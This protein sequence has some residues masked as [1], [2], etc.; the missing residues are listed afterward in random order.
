MTRKKVKL[1]FIVNDSARKTTYKKR[2]KGILKKIEELSILCGIEACAIVYSPFEREPEVWPSDQGVQN[3][4]GKFRSMPEIEQSKKMVNQEGFIGQRILKCNE[5]LMKL[6]KDN[7]EM[8]TTI[9]MFQ[10]LSV[11]SVE[12][13][14]NARVTNLNDLSSVIELNLKEISK[15]LETMNV[16]ETTP[17]QPELQAPTFG[18]QIQMQIPLY[19]LQK[20]TLGYQAQMQGPTLAKPKSEEMTVMNFGQEL[21]MNDNPMQRQLFMDVLHDNGRDEIIMPPPPF[22]KDI[23]AFWYLQSIGRDLLFNERKS[24]HQNLILLYSLVTIAPK[25]VLQRQLVESSL[26]LKLSGTKASKLNGNL[27]YLML[28]LQHEEETKVKLTFIV[29]NAVRKATYKQRKKGILKKIKELSTYCGI[30]SCAIIYSPY[31]EKP[32]FWPSESGVQRVLGKFMTMTEWEQNRKMLDQRGF[33]E[34]SIIKGKERAQ[35]LAQ[36]VEPQEMMTLLNSE[37]EP[38]LIPNPIQWQLLMESFLIGNGNET[39]FS[40]HRSLSHMHQ[41]LRKVKLAYIV[42]DSQRKK[43]YKKRKKSVLKKTEEISTI[44]G[45]EACAIVYSSFDSEPQVWPSQSGVQ[46]VLEKLRSMSEWDQMRNMV[47]Q[48]SFIA[49]S[50]QNKREKVRKLDRDNKE[51]EMTMI[52]YQCLNDGSVVHVNNM[53]V[54][55]LKDLSSVIEQKLLNITT[56][57]EM[58]SVNDMTPFQ[59]QVQNPAYQQHLQMQ[60]S[61]QPRIET[62]ASPQIQMQTQAYESLIEGQSPQTQTP[63]LTLESEEMAVLN[64]R[65]GWDMNTNPMQNQW[66]IDT[67]LEQFEN[68]FFQAQSKVA[69]CVEGSKSSPMDPIQEERLCNKSWVVAASGITDKGRLYKVGKVASTSRLGDTFTNISFSHGGIQDSMIFLQLQKEVR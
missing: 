2:K 47:H 15:R 55:E 64:Y 28:N 65:R 42:N 48:E 27:H 59:P 52:L 13:N 69:S 40:P 34:Q 51:K 16:N 8:E 31:E 53:N 17:N 5:Q 20:P 19:Q 61:H 21:D 22:I 12:P 58:L 1:A 23:I 18:S 3:V 32:E 62:L 38:D 45:V 50:I 33:M 36:A 46:K 6:A 56:R 7:R 30:E 9:V 10:C 24:K 26:I 44:C 57:L 39:T 49:K 54:A 63:A 14:I 43:S 11:G 35:E 25:L 37:E 67:F 29:N 66:F 68:I 4:L 41:K 60:T